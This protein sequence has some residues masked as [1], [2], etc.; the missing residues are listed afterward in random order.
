MTTPATVYRDIKVIELDFY[1]DVPYLMAEAE[2][3][4]CHKTALFS[5]LESW[6]SHL[7]PLEVCGHAYST[8]TKGEARCVE[9]RLIEG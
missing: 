2:C 9:F 4:F 6:T 3:P 8:G 1:Q 7:K 5:C